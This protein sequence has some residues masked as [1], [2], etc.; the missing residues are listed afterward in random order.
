MNA[1][2]VNR[3]VPGTI[4]YLFVKNE[5]Y[6]SDVK[7]QHIKQ[8]NCYRCVRRRRNV[9]SRGYEHVVDPQVFYCGSAAASRSIR[10]TGAQGS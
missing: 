1:Q 7:A 3:N 8:G 2:G 10:S 4:K 9:C 6:C 5:G